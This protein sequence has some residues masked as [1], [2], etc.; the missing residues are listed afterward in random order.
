MGY[1]SDCRQDMHKVA[2]FIDEH[3]QH[4]PLAVNYADNTPDDYRSLSDGITG[5]VSPDAAPVK[6][7]PAIWTN[8]VKPAEVIRVW[9]PS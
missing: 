2:K 1:G 7:S 6:I 4:G 8:G 5:E 9:P 3:L